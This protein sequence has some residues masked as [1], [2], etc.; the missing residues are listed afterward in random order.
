MRK[1]NGRQVGSLQ[2]FVPGS[3]TARDLGFPLPP[4]IAFLDSLIVNFDRMGW[5]GAN[6]MKVVDLDR[7]FAV[8]H[9]RSLLPDKLD[10]APFA[11]LPNRRVLD[12]LRAFTPKAMREA[13]EDILKDKQLGL[14]VRRRDAILRQVDQLIAEH[15]EGDAFIDLKPYA[16]KIAIPKRD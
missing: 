7:P 15:R 8:D 16:P 5:G 4:D 3:K 11:R 10:D 14:L 2:Y 12:R 1:H 6:F 13:L 9:N